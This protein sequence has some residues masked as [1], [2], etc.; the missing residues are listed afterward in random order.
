M[1]LPKYGSD[2]KIFLRKN[3]I[4]AAL[5]GGAAILFSACENDI[6]KIKAFSSPENLPV[7]EAEN[8]ETT[9]T[10][11]GIVRFYLKAP[12]LKRFEADGQPF[13]EFP[14]G[15]LLVKYDANQQII[16]SITARYAKQFLKERKWEAKNNVVAVNAKGDTLKT[17]LLI[18]DERAEKIYSD[19]FVRIIRPDQIISGVGFE[20]SQTLENWKI[21]EP[22]GEIYLTMHPGEGAAPDSLERAN[23]ER[24][25]VDIGK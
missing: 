13:V 19:E 4:I 18:W 1:K 2:K 11:S 12:E 22:R 5:L 20:S 9:F 17:E 25:P 16:S 10:D 21:R 23:P 14:K 15:L 24:Q 6:E 7:I 3:K 8:F